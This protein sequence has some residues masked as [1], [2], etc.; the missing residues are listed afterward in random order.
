MSVILNTISERAK[1]T[2]D[3]KVTDVDVWVNHWIKTAEDF[4]KEVLAEG[5]QSTADQID[6][7][8]RYAQRLQKKKE[9][10]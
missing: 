4:K 3:P 9:A 2:I 10:A 1:K 5:L 8:I 6:D 7:E